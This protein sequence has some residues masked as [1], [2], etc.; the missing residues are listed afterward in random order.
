MEVEV[1]YG[2]G[3][4]YDYLVPLVRL[5]ATV[6][7]NTKHITK[8]V[9]DKMAAEQKANYKR[10]VETAK[11]RVAEAKKTLEIYERVANGEEE[12]G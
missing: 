7:E 4:R 10:N 1:D 9:E 5:N 2:D 8:E 11:R 3:D 6:E 12:E